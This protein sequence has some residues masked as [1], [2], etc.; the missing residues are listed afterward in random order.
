VVFAS[1]V[2][3]ETP[4]YTR[5][6]ARPARGAFLPPVRVPFGPMRFACAIGLVLCAPCFAQ[7]LDINGYSRV[8]VPRAQG[9][10]FNSHAALRDA[11]RAAGFELAG[12]VEE[13]PKEGWPTTLYMTAGIADQERLIF[14]VSVYDVVT[15][16][17]IA[18]CTLSVDDLRPGHVSGRRDPGF[19]GAIGSEA[20]HELIQNMGYQGFGQRARDAN[21]Q[22]QKLALASSQQSTSANAPPSSGNPRMICR[23]AG[24]P[25]PETD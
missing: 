24:A 17:R 4:D 16:T 15:Q 1:F 8:V 9:A 6:V 19:F 18:Y 2:M 10:M 3:A 7:E 12:S 20:I 25:D 23:P 11:L 22:V 13:L 21:W 14:F 5:G